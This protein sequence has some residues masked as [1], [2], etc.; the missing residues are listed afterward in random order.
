VYTRSRDG[1]APVLDALPYGVL[2]VDPDGNVIDANVQAHVLL[3]GLGTPTMRCC[4][5]LFACRAQSGPCERQCLAM[6]AAKSTE[7]LPEIRIDT[8][9]GTSTTALWVTFAPLHHTPGVVVH[10]RPGHAGD[11]RRRSEPHW[12]LGPELHIRAFGRTLIEARGDVLNGDW[13]GQRPGQV[14]KYLVTVRKRVAMADEIAESIWPGSGQRSLSNTRHVIH[15]LR[16]KLEPR[17]APH[18]KSSFV[19]AIASGY[20]LDNQSVWLDVDEFERS[21]Q[22]GRAAMDRRDPSA[23]MGHFEHAIELYRGDFLAD[24]PY[25][26]WAYDER[27][28]LASL[29]TY[30]LRVLA[31]LAHERRDPAAAIKHLARL[32]ELE[33]YDSDVCQDLVT[34]LLSNGHHSEAKRRYMGFARRLR[35]EFDEEPDFDLRSSRASPTPTVRRGSG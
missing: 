16:E 35:R 30:S 24:E 3:P 11:R 7:A 17:R 4:D 13:V 34:T 26:D 15:R 22:E 18:A 9:G 6:R 21:V 32:S 1:F 20:A 25:V 31:L 33:P 29:A 19:I 2:I 5:D 28:R 27:T 14:L 12:L 10:L 23:A 8:A